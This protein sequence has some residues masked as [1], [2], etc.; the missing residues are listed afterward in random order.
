[1]ASRFVLTAQLQLQAPN[2]RAV[3]RT[4]RRELA[5]IEIDLKVKGLEKIKKDLKDSATAMKKMKKETKAAGDSF[6]RF[7]SQLGK[8]IKNVIRYDIARSIVTGL[9][10]AMRQGLRD[11]IKFER[12][13]IKVKS[14]R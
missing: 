7:N 4:I 11:A 14:L 10:M 1:M 5:G 9:S 2:V 12:E 8:A 6:A 13:L 3:V